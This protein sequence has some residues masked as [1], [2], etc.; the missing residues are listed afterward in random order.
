MRCSQGNDEGTP[1]CFLDLQRAGP[2]AAYML[3]GIFNHLLSRREDML[4]LGPSRMR[5]EPHGQVRYLMPSSVCLQLH[6]EF[7]RGSLEGVAS[8]MRLRGCKV[9]T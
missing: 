9:C 2:N 3:K 8:E 7:S 6:E 5:Q 1:L 4:W